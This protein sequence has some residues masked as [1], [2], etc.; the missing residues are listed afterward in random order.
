[1]DGACGSTRH[2]AGF[3]LFFQEYTNAFGIGRSPNVRSFSADTSYN[4]HITTTRSYMNAGSAHYCLN[5]NPIHFP[6]IYGRN[7][8]TRTSPLKWIVV[9]TLFNRCQFTRR[10]SANPEA[11]PHRTSTPISIVRVKPYSRSLK[12][13]AEKNAFCRCADSSHVTEWLAKTRR[14]NGLFFSL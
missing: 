11:T 6:H 9:P 3:V 12:K 4:L 5:R 1:M 7:H 14:A 2:Y 10:G 13:F 8:K